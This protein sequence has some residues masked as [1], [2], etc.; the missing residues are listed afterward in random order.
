M[1]VHV[2]VCVRAEE[3]VWPQKLE[4]QV[5]VSCSPC[6]QG[7]ELLC[8]SRKHSSLLSGLSRFYLHCFRTSILYIVH[9]PLLPLR[10][11][12]IGHPVFLFTFD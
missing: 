9:L 12:L 2:R 10:S 11:T 7:T 1:C 3:R 4:L 5:P 6:V 8:R